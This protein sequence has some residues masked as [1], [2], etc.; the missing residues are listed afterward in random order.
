LLQ[1]DLKT[2]GRL[3]RLATL[4]SPVDGPG[5]VH[6]LSARLLEECD[7]TL[8]A[9]NQER[10]RAALAPHPGLSVPR[11]FMPLT[12]KTVLT[13]ELVDRLT[14]HEFAATASQAARDR[15]GALI[16][17]AAFTSIFHHCAYNADPH[18]GNYLFAPDGR[19]TLLDFGCVKRFS[20]D[21]IA[22]W[23][24][25]AQSLLD[26]DR[27]R[28]RE[29]WAEAGFVGRS[30]RF[31]FDH[32]YEAMR[33][34][35]AHLTDPR[36]SAFTAEAMQR[37][38]DALVFKNKN[39]FR[40]ALPPDWLFVNRLQVGMFSVLAHLGSVVS[41][42]ELFRAALALPIEPLYDKPWVPEPVAF[43]SPGPLPPRPAPPAT[44]SDEALS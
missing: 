10:F 38:H 23:K 26:G 4:L 24:R 32:Q 20:P 18:P 15:A 33:V 34:L 16:F 6:E 3:A 21:F 13:T 22:V 1:G 41:W 17:E 40:L 28:F 25:L 31:D 8:E 19:V 29:T 7:Y 9:E 27:R 37:T 30:W 12:R 43:L 44:P 39:K 36:P 11:V 2:V 42:S 14:F 5:V 35:Y